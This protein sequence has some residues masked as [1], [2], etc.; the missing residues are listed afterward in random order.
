M[1]YQKETVAAI[2]S[3]KGDYVLALKGSQPLFYEEIRAYFDEEVLEKLKRK[4]GC[5][6][7]QWSR[8][9]EGLPSGNIIS[10]KI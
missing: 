2:V 9:M 4:E 8:S 6:K 10:P 1:P 7:K 5:Y 3:G